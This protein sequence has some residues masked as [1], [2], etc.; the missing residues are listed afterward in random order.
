MTHV[1]GS[2]MHEA[3]A[4]LLE[5]D[6]E[7]AQHVIESDARVDVLASG[8][9]EKTFDIISSKHP[10]GPELRALLGAMRMASSLE[11]MG[12]LAQHVAKQARM[13]HPRPAVPSE[14]R[15]VFMQ[16]GNLAEEIVRRTGE[17]IATRDLSLGGDIARHDAE[18]DRLHRQLFSTVLAPT[19]ELGVE[20]AIDVTLLSRYY[21][22]YADHAVSI[23]RRVVTIVTGEA[24]VGVTLD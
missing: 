14:L 2:A 1:V 22:R 7:L 4:A 15:D 10:E 23:T 11:R 5:A 6:L 9:E 13:R 16:M 21:E 8:V 24:Y 3:S 19:W 20:A 17:V 12:D 18:M